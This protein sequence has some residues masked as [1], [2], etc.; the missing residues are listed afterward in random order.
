MGLSGIPAGRLIFFEQGKRFR[1]A[2]RVF[3]GESAGAGASQGVQVGAAPQGFAQVA[4]QRPDVRAFA[5][6]DPEF[7]VGKSQAGG[8]RDDDVRIGP[9]ERV[10]FGRGD[11]VRSEGQQFQG[12]EFRCALGLVFCFCAAL[13]CLRASS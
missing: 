4:G 13:Y 2:Q 12:V 1:N 5:A 7:G 6:G 10:F 8:V 9:Q 3:G 11:R